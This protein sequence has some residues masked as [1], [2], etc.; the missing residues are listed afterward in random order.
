MAFLKIGKYIPTLR[1]AVP[2][3]C[4]PQLEAS[5]GRASGWSLSRV[6]LGVCAVALFVLSA[7]IAGTLAV[8]TVRRVELV[9]R[10]LQEVINETR[11]HSTERVTPTSVATVSP[12]LGGADVINE[13]V[14]AGNPAEDDGVLQNGTHSFLRG[15]RQ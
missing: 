12:A 9:S 15:R 6:C 8:H 10:L 14:T 4:S 2:L 5:G 1:T 13:V 11:V 7:L 3:H